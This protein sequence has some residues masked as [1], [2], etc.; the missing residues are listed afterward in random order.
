[1]LVYHTV[2]FGCGRSCR[3]EDVNRS[4]LLIIHEYMWIARIC[5]PITATYC[6]YL[7]A[8]GGKDGRKILE[9]LLPLSP[10]S[11]RHKKHIKNSGKSCLRWICHW[12]ADFRGTKYIL[13]VGTGIYY[14]QSHQTMVRTPSSKPV[15][16]PGLTFFITPTFRSNL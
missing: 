15:L 12:G 13:S 3:I 6:H 4:L 14:W 1:M 10:K 9:I 16:S 5:T 11:H 8:P 7:L 2:K